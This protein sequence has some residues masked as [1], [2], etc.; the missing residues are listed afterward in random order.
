MQDVS[1]CPSSIHY[2]SIAATAR[3]TNSLTTSSCL[4]RERTIHFQI[5]QAR[6]GKFLFTHHSSLLT[7]HTSLITH[8]RGILNSD[9][10]R[11]LFCLPLQVPTLTVCL[12]IYLVDDGPIIHPTQHVFVVCCMYVCVW[13]NVV[14][15]KRKPPRPCLLLLLLLLSRCS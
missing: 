1:L 12:L 11:C 9:S 5:V 2:S 14:E 4:Q 10:R 7:P 8:Q 6:R 15:G 13:H 3:K